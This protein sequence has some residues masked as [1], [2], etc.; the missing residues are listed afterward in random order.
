MNQGLLDFQSFYRLPPSGVLH[1]S[2][3]FSMKSPRLCSSPERMDVKRNSQLYSSSS[4]SRGWSYTILHYSVLNTPNGVDRARVEDDVRLAFALWENLV[5][6]SLV[7]AENEVR[8][9]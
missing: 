1:T 3:L 4:S 8:K 5:N 2:T 7:K 6:I 9:I